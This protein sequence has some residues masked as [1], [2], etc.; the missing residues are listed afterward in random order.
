MYRLKRIKIA[1]RSLREGI[2]RMRVVVEILSVL[3]DARAR[4]DREKKRREC[5]GRRE[6]Y[7]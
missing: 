1:R 5:E 7:I 6:L 3:G 2:V 4:M